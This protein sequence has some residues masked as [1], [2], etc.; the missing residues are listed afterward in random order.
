M[1]RRPVPAGRRGAG[2]RRDRL[3]VKRGRTS[4]RLLRFDRERKSKAGKK[5]IGRH[6]T[7]LPIDIPA[8]YM[9]FGEEILLCRLLILCV[10]RVKRRCWAWCC[11]HR[12]RHRPVC[13]IVV[14]SPGRLPSSAF[15]LPRAAPSIRRLPA[16][17]HRPRCL[18]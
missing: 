17:A 6:L 5:R 3:L 8:E 12:R 11:Q 14:L 16:A 13:R 15:L 7:C 4:S 2:R 10:F 1:P 9:K 18:C